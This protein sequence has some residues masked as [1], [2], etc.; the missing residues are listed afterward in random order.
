MTY[1]HILYEKEAKIATITMNHPEKRNAMSGPVM[2]ELEKAWTEADEDDEVRVLIIKGAGDAFCAGA[3]MSPPP[4]SA[5]PSRTRFLEVDRLHLQRS[6]E[7]YLRLRN[8]SKA[9]IAQVHG[10][11]ITLGTMLA[12]MCDLIFIAEDAR[13]S[14]HALIGPLGAGTFEPLWTFNM[15]ARKAKELVF[16]YGHIMDGKEAERV[17]W[18]NKAVPADKLEEEVRKIAKVIAETPLEVLRLEKLA[19]N[20]AQEAMGLI[21]AAMFGA[22]MDAICHQTQATQQFQKMIREK[23]W[24]VARDEWRGV[25]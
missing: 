20:R 10:Y 18:A 9:T 5:S 25:L 8:V 15:G 2:N 21:H 13:I 17:G 1:Q 11:C 14:A 24:K 19:V 22:E 12:M 7:Q 6:I 16:Q 3:D 23:G 4:S